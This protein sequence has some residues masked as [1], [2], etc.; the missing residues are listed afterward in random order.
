MK[1]PE[2]LAAA[3][4]YFSLLPG[5]GEKTSMRHALTMMGWRAE[6]LE[7]FGSAVKE[8][9]NIKKCQECFIVTDQE[10]CSI[11]ESPLR[12]KSGIICVVESFAD[13][14][15]IEKSGEY[16]GLFH[17]LGG[18][19]NPLM[20]IGPEELTINKL[21]LRIKDL[22]VFEII[23]ALNPTVEG[24]VTSSYI[25]QNVP[26]GVKVERIGL[27]VPMGGSLEYLDALTITK[28]LENRRLL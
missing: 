17:I 21:F 5:V 24:D 25:K 6:E 4:S 28:A 2:K 27:G 7:A 13:C 23:L 16:T 10:F 1:L 20:G 3:I 8:L 22:N 26:T 9:A 19:L 14:M 18:V 12:Q 11:C 15:A